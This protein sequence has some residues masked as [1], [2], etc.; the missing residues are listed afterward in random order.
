MQL[1]SFFSSKF[2]EFMTNKVGLNKNVYL[3]NCFLCFP[4]ARPC[5]HVC[6][7]EKNMLF[8]FKFVWTEL[9]I[10]SQF[11]E[12]DSLSYRLSIFSL[13]ERLLWPS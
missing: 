6:N 5:F 10:K 13:K 8:K 9:V 3:K 4:Q 7:Y 1:L 2:G 12:L 11:K